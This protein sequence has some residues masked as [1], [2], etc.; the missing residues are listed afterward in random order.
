MCQMFVLI[1]KLWVKNRCKSRHFIVSLINSARVMLGC[2]YGNNNAI[3]Q[4]WAPWRMRVCSYI[5]ARH[6]CMPRTLATNINPW[7]NGTMGCLVM[8]YEYQKQLLGP[9]LSK[10]VA[11]F[12]VSCCRKLQ[13]ISIITDLRRR[14]IKLTIKHCL[15][16]TQLFPWYQSCKH[17]PL[18]ALE[19]SLKG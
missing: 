9:L 13:I 6:M 3:A 5:A 18:H 14:F 7:S 10:L 11:Q 8:R 1:D 12:S 17:G 2:W 19:R 4:L 16:Y 15:Y